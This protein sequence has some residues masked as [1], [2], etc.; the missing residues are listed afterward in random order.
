M[1]YNYR[2]IMECIEFKVHNKITVTDKEK[3]I[4][5]K[6]CEWKHH[7]LMREREKCNG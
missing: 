1:I 4:Y 7:D 2:H 6:L 5:L 3:F